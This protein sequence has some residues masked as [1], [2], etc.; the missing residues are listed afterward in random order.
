MKN[1]LTIKDIVLIALLTTLYLVFYGVAMMLGSVLGLYGHSLGPGIAAFLGGSVLYFMNYKVGKTG[2]FLILQAIVSIL[3]LTMGMGHAFFILIALAFA[4][5]ADLI[6][7]RKDNPSVL[8]LALSSG[9]IHVGQSLGVI[10]PIMFALDQYKEELI[11]KGK[12]PEVIEESIRVTTGWVG[13]SATIIV[14]ILAFAGIFLG[15][16]LLKKHLHREDSE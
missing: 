9:L 3:F 7:S 13:L 1:K 16:F 6:S 15:H 5:V 10:V 12:S 8:R 2:Q 14:F 4:L 11:S